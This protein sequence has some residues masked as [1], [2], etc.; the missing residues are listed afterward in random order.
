MISVTISSSPYLVTMCQIVL[1]QTFVPVG[2]L[3]WVLPSTQIPGFS[4]PG[5]VSK[6]VTSMV[7]RSLPSM[8]LP[9]LYSFVKPGYSS[10]SPFIIPTNSS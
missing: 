10:W 6:F 4:L 2:S 8:V 5:P 9:M 3:L 7:Q 1:R